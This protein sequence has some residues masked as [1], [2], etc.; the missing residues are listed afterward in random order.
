MKK[1]LLLILMN[2]I[3]QQN[4]NAQSPLWTQTMNVS[5]IADYLFAVKTVVDVD[6]NIIVLNTQSN[7][8]IVD[9]KIYLRKFD[10][11]GNIIWTTIWDNNGSGSPRGFDLASDS[12]GDIY[13][14]GGFMATDIPLIVKF[15]TNGNYIWQKTNVNAF[16]NGSFNHMILRLGKLY[17]QA[18]LGVAVFDV[19]GNEQWSVANL[20]LAMNVDYL[21][22]LVAS[23]SGTNNLVRYNTDGTVD[24]AII[25][26]SAYKIAINYDNEIYII[27]NYGDYVIEA[28]DSIGYFKFQ[29]PV[30]AS[31]PPFGD[32]A[33]DL[34]ADFNGDVI[35]IGVNDTM[36]KY[37]TDGF[38]IWKKPMNGLDDYLISSQL[39]G[40]NFI[41]VAGTLNGFAGYDAK[42]SIFDL[43]G[44]EFWTGIYGSNFTQEF[45]VDV[46]YDYSGIYVLEDSISN[47]DLIKFE[48]PLNQT[49]I[50]Y[51]LICVDS[52]WYDPLNPIFINVQ[53]F[54]GN[55]THLNYPSV[56]IAA[57]NNDTISNVYNLVNFFAHLGN[58]TQIYQDTITVSGITDFSNYHF[59]ISEGF[60]DTTVE[61]GL[62]LTNGIEE[63]SFDNASIFPNPTESS[64][65]ISNSNWKGEYEISIYDYN[66]RLI[67]QD[68]IHSENT[69][70]NVSDLS[71]GMYIL[72]LKD[73]TSIRHFK[74]IK[75]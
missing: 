37:D 10:T 8:S 45:S 65:A 63:A 62:C 3:I 42:V 39:I 15:S 35:A 7:P 2:T 17:L 66:S 14:V 4:I 74:F 23:V 32:V 72:Q 29:T 50:D 67:K 69:T 57:P 1:I 52:V 44:N 55:A 33:L 61:I 28:Y 46:A 25:A 31:T 22:R 30:L 26:L 5:P 38:L 60:G 6:G 48:N 21:G 73:R 56:Q 27:S 51:S 36:Y 34:I 54:N 18:T 58:A 71:S 49:D 47:S 9:Q 20:P 16:A 70:L 59:Y 43:Q 53:V 64:I 12:V 75:Q 40:Y 19:S 68:L 11:D 13:V 24:F 41:L